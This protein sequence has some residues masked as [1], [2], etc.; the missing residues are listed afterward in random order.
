MV[1]GIRGATTVIEDQESMI[2]EATVELL[3]AMIVGNQLDSTAVASLFITV[4]PD[5][6]SAF[7]AKAV[8]AVPGWDLVP[9]M[10]AVEVDVPGSLS[11]CIR[12]LLHVNTDA[13]QRDIRHMYLRD[14]IQL[15]PDLSQS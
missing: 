15:R 11:R 9:L 6:R 10:C 2:F 13:E 12:L 3:S 14:A 1:R 4:S 8:R 5:L 7:P